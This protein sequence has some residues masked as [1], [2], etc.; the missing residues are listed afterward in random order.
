MPMCIAM[1]QNHAKNMTCQKV[2]FTRPASGS[3]PVQISSCA[4]GQNS[5]TESMPNWRA[6]MMP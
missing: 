1:L 2:N 4:F 5:P 3:P 6:P